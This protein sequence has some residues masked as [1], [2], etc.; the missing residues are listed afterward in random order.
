MSGAQSIGQNLPKITVDQANVVTSQAFVDQLEQT[1]QQLPTQVKET[2][3]PVIKLA[4][5]QNGGITIT[6]QEMAKKGTF[7][8]RV[9]GGMVKAVLDAQAGARDGRISVEDVHKYLEP[10]LRDGA[11]GNKYAEWEKPI[12]HVLMAAMDGRVKAMVGDDQVN[13][14]GKEAARAFHGIVRSVIGHDAGVASAAARA[15]QAIAKL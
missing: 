13:W 5:D 10:A 9:D 11:K 4:L 8:M 7:T 3:K 1:L 2:E 14:A 12:V 15:E 6:L